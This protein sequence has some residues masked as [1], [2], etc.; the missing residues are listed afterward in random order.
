MYACCRLL[1]RLACELCLELFVE[2]LCV[3][4]P[5][6]LPGAQDSQPARPLCGP[7]TLSRM[8]CQEA[9]RDELLVG[10]SCERLPLAVFP[11]VSCFQRL[12]FLRGQLPCLFIRGLSRCW[13]YCLDT[14]PPT[15][16]HPL[17]ASFHFWIQFSLHPRR[18][19]LG[20]LLLKAG[21]LFQPRTC[22]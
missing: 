3:R 15:L 21:P 19:S 13:R 12:H 14:L 10:V 18:F 20:L 1:G 16:S 11:P 22:T 5:I 17:G 4:E 2:S 9:P 6:G 7:H 8:R